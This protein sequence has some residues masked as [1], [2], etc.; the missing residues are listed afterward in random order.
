MGAQNFNSAP[1]SPKIG[2]FSLAFCI[3]GQIFVNKKTIQGENWNCDHPH[4]FCQTFAAVC[5]KIGTFCPPLPPST[6]TSSPTTTL[7][8][9]N[10]EDLFSAIRA[11]RDLAQL[12]PRY[13]SPAFYQICAFSVPQRRVVNVGCSFTPEHTERTCSA[14]QTPQLDV[15]K[16]TP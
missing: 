10:Y 13:F 6:Q 2:D 7:S 12:R 3:F 8:S 5:R 11:R 15:G 16:S 4:L 1:N 14:R 9:R